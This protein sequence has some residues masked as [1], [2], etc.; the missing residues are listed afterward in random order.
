MLL[1]QT[2]QTGK[3]EAIQTLLVYLCLELYFPLPTEPD[4]VSP[5]PLKCSSSCEV[6][7]LMSQDS[8]FISNALI[9]FTRPAQ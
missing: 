9:V 6:G 1:S 4:T 7:F 5:F 3:N 2:E 8:H